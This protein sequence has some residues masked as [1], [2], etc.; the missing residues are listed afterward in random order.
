MAVVVSRISLSFY[1]VFKCII[2][3]S[4][5]C[6]CVCVC[7]CVYRVYAMPVNSLTFFIHKIYEHV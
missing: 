6:A 7:V 5:V 2:F 1:T 4:D 3:V